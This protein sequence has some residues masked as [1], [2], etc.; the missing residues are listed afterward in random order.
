MD[1]DM[2]MPTELVEAMDRVTA[3]ENMELSSLLD[4]I[5]NLKSQKDEH[6]AAKIYASK[7]LHAVAA[8]KDTTRQIADNERNQH[9][10][11][12]DELHE[13]L[14]NHTLVRDVLQ[15][16][17][18]NIQMQDTVNRSLRTMEVENR[19]DQFPEK[20]ALLSHCSRNLDT[21]KS[22]VSAVEE[23]EEIEREILELRMNYLDLLKK[24]KEKW[25]A[26]FDITVPT[27]NDSEAVEQFQ[28]KLKERESKLQILVSMLQGLISTSGFMWGAENYY[29]QV[30]LLCDIASTHGDSVE[31]NAT[32][33]EI[34]KYHGLKE[35]HVEKK[36]KK[37]IYFTSTPTHSKQKKSI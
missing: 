11:E 18:F 5:M 34:N 36:P 20:G 3:K 30:L 22:L 8:E 13:A 24:I 27:Q 6:V 4:H 2:K 37:Q 29:I 21:C 28:N 17:A 26:V 25:E 31:L 14:V 19:V 1:K 12:T 33:A 35:G 10:A 7:E 16:A 23:K 32:I 15:K 9:M